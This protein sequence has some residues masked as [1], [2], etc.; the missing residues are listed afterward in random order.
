MTEHVK[1]GAARLYQRGRDANGWTM[2]AMALALSWGG[3]TAYDAARAAWDRM[4]LTAAMEQRI[5]AE[6]RTS[7]SNIVAAVLA[8]KEQSK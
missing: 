2:A 4:G 6:V 3:S 7:E 1:A 5:I 8:A